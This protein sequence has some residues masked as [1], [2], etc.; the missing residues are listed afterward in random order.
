MN[1]FSSGFEP[2]SASAGY[3]E[4]TSRNAGPETLKRAK[5][6]FPEAP[7]EVDVFVDG[8]LKRLMPSDSA[9][10][11]LERARDVLLATYGKEPADSITKR[12]AEHQLWYAPRKNFSMADL[13]AAQKAVLAR[14]DARIA[15]AKATK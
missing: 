9:V 6:R 14:L 13:N 10:E 5:E 11:E 1:R 12:F 2:V 3:I 8:F 15:M 7:D 4:I